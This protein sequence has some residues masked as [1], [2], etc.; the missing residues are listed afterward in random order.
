MYAGVALLRM[1]ISKGC[2][3]RLVPGSILT[4]SLDSKCAGRPP[5]PPAAS[6]ELRVR[7][8]ALLNQ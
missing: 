4:A 2:L 5:A 6:V 3:R 8:D 1:R 7:D